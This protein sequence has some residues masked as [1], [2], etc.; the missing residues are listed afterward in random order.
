[1]TNEEDLRNLEEKVRVYLGKKHTAA[2]A[3][4][5]DSP[6]DAHEQIRLT[7]TYGTHPQVTV[8]L[9]IQRDWL[10]EAGTRGSLIETIGTTVLRNYREAASSREDPETNSKEA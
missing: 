7:V 5:E 6:G 8:S 4:L 3:Y 1:M 9:I 2:E 10:K